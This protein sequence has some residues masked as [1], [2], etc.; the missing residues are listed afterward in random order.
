MAGAI[1]ERSIR[2]G[3]KRITE[4]DEQTGGDEGGHAFAEPAPQH[5]DDLD[6][7]SDEEAGAVADTIGKPAGR[8]LETKECEIARRENG[9]NDRGRNLFLLDPPE[10]IQA[11]HDALDRGD[12][13]RQVEKEVTTKAASIRRH[14]ISL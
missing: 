6:G 11:V 12:P 8:Q 9:G 13:V 7:G 2:P 3:T 4:R 5:A 10:E 14:V 1:Q